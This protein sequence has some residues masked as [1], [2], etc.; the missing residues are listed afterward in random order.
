MGQKRKA[1]QAEVRALRE[2]LAA[3]EP[4]PAVMRF[5]RFGMPEGAIKPAPIRPFEVAKPL[6]GVLPDGMAA[7]MAMDDAIDYGAITWSAFTDGL[8]WLGY[9]YLA[10]LAQRPEYRRISETIAKEMTRK[11]IRIQST[12]SDDGK[13][14]KVRHIEVAFKRLR[15]Q[16]R[17]RRAIELDGFFGR[18][19]I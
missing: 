4:A 18:G 16:D 7:D 13:A 19:Q 9:P 8:Q 15:V 2:E 14:D 3:R 11:W 17:V 10:E 1:L 6:A 12:G 5:G